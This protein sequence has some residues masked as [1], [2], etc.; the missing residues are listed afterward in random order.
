MRAKIKDF[1][2]IPS[3]VR[4]EFWRVT[5]HRNRISLLVICVMIFGMELFNMARVLFWSASGLGTVN[6]RIYFGL[7]CALFTAAAAYLLL[8][9]LLRGRSERWERV[10]QYGAVLFFL[11]WHVCINAYDLSRNAD[12][13]LMI[14]I[15]AILGISVFILMPAKYA[16]LF[17]GAAYLLFLLL[18]GRSLTTGDK[19]NI[20]FTA[21]VALTVSMTSCHHHTTVLSQRLEI[22]RMNERLRAMAQHDALTGLLNKAAFQHRVAPYLETEGATLLMVDLDDFKSVNDQYG[23]PCGDFVLK[24]LALRLGA[25]FPEAV[26][27]SRVGGDE[28]ALLVSGGDEASLHSAAQELIHAVSGITWHG[29]NVG[30]GCSIGGCRVGSAAVTYDQLYSETDR[31]LYQAKEQGKGLFCLNS[32]P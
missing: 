1:F 30:A 21:I 15:T 16:V 13:E 22:G 25:A 14:Y 6:N 23:H 11:L 29:R 17:H 20:T 31:A 3:Q 9:C 7:Y 8:D 19:I 10:L 24:E 27:I 4:P 5:L 12:A 28:F 2:V 18:A 32:L 26:G